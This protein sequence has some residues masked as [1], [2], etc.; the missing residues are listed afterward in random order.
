MHKIGERTV[1]QYLHK[2]GLT[3]MDRHSTMVATLKKDAP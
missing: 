2:K 1:I 3:L